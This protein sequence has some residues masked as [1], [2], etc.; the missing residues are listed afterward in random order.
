MNKNDELPEVGKR[1]AFIE[2]FLDEE[3]VGCFDGFVFKDLFGTFFNLCEVRSWRYCDE[4]YRTKTNDSIFLLE[5]LRISFVGANVVKYDVL[6]DG[7]LGLT[8]NKRNSQYFKTLAA[9][10]SQ[11]YLWAKSEIRELKVFIYC[12]TV[13]EFPFDFPFNDGGWLS[14]RRYTRN[15]ALWTGTPAGEIYFKEGDIVEVKWGNHVHLCIVCDLPNSTDCYTVVTYSINEKGEIHYKHL[16]TSLLDVFE[17]CLTVPE[18]VQ[19][20]LREGLQKFK[21]GSVV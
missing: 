5:D 21:S 8:V 13:T 10:E 12:Y 7:S 17:S 1:V 3:Y 19:E 16:Q 15:G 14:K 18:N 4:S 20:I 6:D 2:S 11:M 9:A